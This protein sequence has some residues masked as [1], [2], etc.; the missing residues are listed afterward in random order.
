MKLQSLTLSNFKGIRHLHVNLQGKNAT[1]FGDNGAGKTTLADAWHWLLF[2]KD[3]QN[4]KDFE[5]KTLDRDNNPIPG[6]E[7]EVE[8]V[9]DL[10]GKALTLKKSYKEV[11]TKKRG[12][13]Q[14]SF[15]GHTTDHY[16]DGVPVAKKDYLAKIAEIVDEDIFKLLTN[17][18]AFNDLHWEKR[19]QI[20]LQVCGDVTDQ[21]VISSDQALAELPDILSGRK[22]EDHRK[23]IASRQSKINAELKVLPAR[24]SEV[25]HSLPDISQVSE[26]QIPADL[27]A[28]RQARADKEQ[29]KLRLIQGGEIAERTKQLREIEAELQQLVTSHKAK[30]DEASA[31][32]RAKLHAVTAARRNVETDISLLGRKAAEAKAEASRINIKIDALRKKWREENGKGF[33]HTAESS[34][35][36]CGQAIPEAQLEEA[37]QKAEAV[38][39]EVK[40]LA[41]EEINAEG[42]RLKEQ[43]TDAEALAA[44]HEVDIEKLNGILTDMQAEEGRLQEQLQQPVAIAPLE[45]DP[46]YT[47][48]LEVKNAAQKGIEELKAGTGTAQ[49]SIQAE[50][51][52]LTDSINAL[53]QAM[54]QVKLHKRGQERIKELQAEEQQLAREY[55]QLERQ[56]YLCEEFVRTK[57]RLLDQRINSRF[58]LAMFK[59][60]EVQVNGGLAE[61]CE[62]L[63]QG[64]PWSGGL[65]N[66]AQVNV[67]IDI[68]NTLSEHY[69]FVAP[70]FADNAESVTQII[71]TQAQLIRLVV[72]AEDEKLRLEVE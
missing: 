45:S 34:C 59:L 1:I 15:S 72:S 22:L 33:T 49:A 4:R 54:A 29:A 39:N 62:T 56:Q 46:A 50:I 32:A 24:I 14:A 19:R 41:L 57:V 30:Q 20:L 21:D 60:F 27:A 68:I 51:D 58:K 38:F 18:R 23:V 69:S 52:A 31:E 37:R 10:D 64:V 71:P 43:L 47:K 5:I 70:I 28:L 9:I 42:R 67:G 63:F 48:V 26:E 16:I 12:S 7:H 66:G 36:T 44:K 53:E 8:A 13:A 17:P 6:L 61:C 2:D 25:Q 40:A 3:S 11:W 35:P 65:N 55:E